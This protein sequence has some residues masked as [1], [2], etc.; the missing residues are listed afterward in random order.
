MDGQKILK[1]LTYGWTKIKSGTS[2]WWGIIRGYIFKENKKDRI[3]VTGG[4]GFIGH[5]LANELY[6][7]GHEVHVWDNLSVGKKERLNGGII[8]EELDILGV[9]PHF[10]FD[11]V[12]HLASPTSVPESLENPEKYK[13]GCYDMTKRVVDLCRVY[14]VRE[15]VFSSTSAVYGDTNEFPT[16]ETSELN[17]LSPYAQYKLVAERLIESVNPHTDL[18]FTVCRF[19]NV[20]G[21]EQ[22]DSGS[23]APAVAIFLKQYRDNKDLTVTGDGMQTRDYIYVKD[24]VE[25]LV[26]TINQR[27]Y[28]RETFNLGYGQ[29]TTILSIA[30]TLNHPITYIP[31]R[32]EPK[33]SLADITKAKRMFKWHPKVSVKEWISEKTK[34]G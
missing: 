11:V 6:R 20:F 14:S 28:K 12:F 31:Q 21:E 17:P 29:D 10:N 23:Y 19:F 25:F 4:A 30:Q 22:H 33:K 16:K 18:K 1:T 27:K 7:L 8:F 15:M 32:M 9:V 3:L 5:H 26:R 2:K 34:N 24:V 13:E